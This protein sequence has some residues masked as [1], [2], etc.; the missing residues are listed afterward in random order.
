MQ[1]SG[2]VYKDVVNHLFS[3]VISIYKHALFKFF[4]V[5]RIFYIRFFLL[6][7][8]IHRFTQ[9]HEQCIKILQVMHIENM[10]CGILKEGVCLGT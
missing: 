3:A 4:H 6:G 10:Y 7:S 8:S 2:N 9:R 5:S 1:N